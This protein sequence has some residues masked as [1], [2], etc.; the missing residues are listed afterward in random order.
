MVLKTL[1]QL[2]ELIFYILVI[3]M[4]PRD[5]LKQIQKKQENA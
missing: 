4:A 2:S 1:I 3:P 5:I